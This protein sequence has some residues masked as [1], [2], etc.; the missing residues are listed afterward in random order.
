MS[1]LVLSSIRSQRSAVPNYRGGCVVLSSVKYVHEFQ[2]T[3]PSRSTTSAIVRLCGS[4]TV[5]IHVPLAEHDYRYQAQPQDITGFNSRAPRGARLASENRSVKCTG[6]SIHVPLAEHDIQVSADGQAW[7]VS[8]HVPLAEHD[9]PFR[10][11]RAGREGF[12]SRAP[13]GARQRLPSMTTSTESFNSRAPRG[14]RP[15]RSCTRRQ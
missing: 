6:V 2:F 8:I 11:V 14:A 13:R 12:N 5:S 4:Y 9:L 3:C 15:V 10:M 7:S 1:R